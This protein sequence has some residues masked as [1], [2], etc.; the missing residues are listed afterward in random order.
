MDTTSWH[1]VFI[2]VSAATA[3]FALLM[4]HRLQTQY[5]DDDSK[6][7]RSMLGFLRGSAMLAILVIIVAGANLLRIT[8]T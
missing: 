1:W 6:Q 3:A 2:G 5:P 4:R 8:L 7:M